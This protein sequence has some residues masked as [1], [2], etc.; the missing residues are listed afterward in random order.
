M[1]RAFV[2]DPT[3]SLD[4]PTSFSKGD[5]LA[6]TIQDYTQ[7]I[8]TGRKPV[9]ALSELRQR[10]KSGGGDQIRKELEEAISAEKSAETKTGHK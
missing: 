10:W 3:A 8:I 6:Q 9:S 7:A 5:A 2:T 4:S 1:S